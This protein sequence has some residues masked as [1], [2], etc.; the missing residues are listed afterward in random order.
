M[1]AIIE[2]KLARE[3]R[4]PVNAE[5]FLTFAV[6]L[7]GGERPITLASSSSVVESPNRRLS[8]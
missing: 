6:P 5:E 1:A 3:A 4:A 7:I 8:I 2:T